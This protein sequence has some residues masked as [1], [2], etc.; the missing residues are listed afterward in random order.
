MTNTVGKDLTTTV[1]GE[2]KT[3]VTGKTTE[4]YNG[5]LETTIT[6]EEKHT[7]N[8]SQINNITGDQTNTIG[9]SQTTTVTG[10]SSLSAQNITNTASETLSNSAK[11]I[12]NTAAEKLSNSAAEIENTASKSITDKVGD[13]VSRTMT[14]SQIKESVVDGANSN[15]STKT[16]S[17]DMNIVTD[18][19]STSTLSQL[20]GSVNTS[21]KEV[22][23]S[24][25]SVKSLNNVQTVSEDTTKITD[26]ATGDFSS[27]SQ[28]A[29][30]FTSQVKNNSGGS[31]T[32]TDTATTSEQKL[33]S[34]NIIDIL[35]DAETGYVN[36]TVSSG[37]G[38][39]A[40][41]TSVK[42]GT[43]DITNT[44]EQG[45]ITHEAKDLVNKAA[46]NITNTAGTRIQDK[47]GTTTVTT[48]DGLTK[49]TNEA[50]NHRTQMDY[51]EVLKDLG[52]KGNATIDKD[53]S[54][55]GNATVAGD[56]TAKSYKVGDK[57]Y[58]D[59]NGINGNGQKVT[60]VADGDV[61]EG[62]TDAVNGGQ[63]HATNQRVSTVE[64]RM[65]GV[66]N[67]V[68]RVENRVDN[69]DNRIDKVGASAAAMANLH[70]MDFDEDSKVS[71][72]AAVGNYRSETAGALGVFYRPTDRVMMNIST[73]FGNGENMVGGGVSFKLG[74][75]S[76]RLQ[77]AEATN[78]A[79]S[80]QVTNLQNRLDALL[81]VLNP[82]LSK[83]FPDVPA[84]H[85]AYEA[86]SRLAG[87]GIIQGYEDGK[88]HGER[89]MTRYEMAEII[90]NA[91]SK[92]AKAEAK[93]VEE[94]RP[95]LQAMAAQRKA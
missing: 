4:N 32:V 10:D 63:L 88:Y 66:E 18:G 82:S 15:T 12:T 59:E 73:S 56:V 35:K 52:V 76:K 24:G 21:L 71:V 92:G 20:A 78:A 44:A 39:D 45:T 94:F 46:K 28:K 75:S 50:G 70:P 60:N 87:N 91:L 6:G 27:R 29:N 41:S 25:N 61:S 2:M 54:V 64:N 5:G 34:G 17:K 38:D 37:T 16:A 93:L 22:D 62:S 85:W 77:Q 30:G 83:D 11:N 55:G 48:T 43:A 26:T 53:L 90:Y 47:V 49:L 79:L 80:K 13:N 31:N 84:N 86:V 68:D 40:T 95:E 72:A 3:T 69:L 33:V 81:G 14:T 9:G 51:A 19:I 42:Q 58:I 57:T 23:S 36:T 74:K 1:G 89:T 67:R 7:V 8:G 65:D